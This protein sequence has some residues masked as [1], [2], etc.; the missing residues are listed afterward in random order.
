ML[1]QNKSLAILSAIILLTSCGTPEIAEAVVTTAA[2][3]AAF[4]MTTTTVTP[5][6]TTALTTKATPTTTLPIAETATAITQYENFS[7]INLLFDALVNKN[8][9][10]W[11]IGINEDGYNYLIEK[12]DINDY[13]VLEED[14]TDPFYER[15]YKIRV[16]VTRSEAPEFP[17]GERIWIYSSYEPLDFRD[18]EN[19]RDYLWDIYYS[20]ETDIRLKIAAY[21]SFSFECYETADV[22]SFLKSIAEEHGFINES[23]NDIYWGSV[24]HC[25]IQYTYVADKFLPDPPQSE[26]NGSDGM[27]I[28]YT[29]KSLNK[30]IQDSLVTDI[31]LY[32]YCTEISDQVWMD[33]ESSGLNGTYIIT[34]DYVE[35]TYYGDW[36]HIIPAKTI[37]YF[38]DESETPRLER[39]DLVEDFGY[40][41]CRTN[42]VI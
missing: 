23:Y 31:D 41:P 28:T 2:T 19:I 25:A 39:L 6:T 8:K 33:W 12:I 36:H 20:D 35:I 22:D 13:E 5:V 11:D 38:F 15:V 10:V 18:S 17:V 9:Y 32:N 16:N 40:E 37:R 4:E 34:D 14:R 24:V 26:P 27:S 1:K 21:Y 42:S 30:T 3:T 29:A 7:D